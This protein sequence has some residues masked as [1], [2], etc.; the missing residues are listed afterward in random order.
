[1]IHIYRTNARTSWLF[2]VSEIETTE[3]F[4]LTNRRG[5][6]PY[7][8]L[9]RRET[10][11]TEHRVQ[12]LQITDYKPKLR[13]QKKG[14]K[15]NKLDYTSALA[16]K[17]FFFLTTRLSF[18]GFQN[19]KRSMRLRDCQATR[20]QHSLARLRCRNK[21]STV[22]STELLHKAQLIDCKCIFFLLRMFLVLS[23]SC[24]IAKKKDFMFVLAWGFPYPTENWMH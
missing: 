24:A 19:L 2:I 10:K 23:L 12:R 18:E 13:R 1:M 6:R 20:F 4:F 21:W 9:L 16:I 8:N 11:Q 7:W 14:N 3:T 22:S 15:E 17:F 5:L